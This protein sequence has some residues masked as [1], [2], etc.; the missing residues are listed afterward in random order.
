MPHEDHRQPAVFR[1]AD[2]GGC[3]FAHLARLTGRP[4][5]QARRDGLHRVDDEKL[6]L[7]L[8][9]VAEDRGEIGLAREVELVVQGTGALGTQAHLAERL[10]G[11]DVEHPAARGRGAGGDFEQ[12]CRLADARL[13]RQQDRGAGHDAPAEHAVELAHPRGAARGLA[14]VDLGDGARRTGG[15]EGRHRRSRDAGGGRRFDDG[16]PLLA[17]TAAA[18]PFGARPP[19]LRAPI[20]QGARRAF[21]CHGSTLAAASDMRAARAR[22]SRCAARA[23]P[24]AKGRDTRY[25]TKP[26]PRVA[27]PR[28]RQK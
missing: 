22:R 25:G 23:A 17:F 7:R 8:V 4:V 2:E 9:D 16:A 5:D 13:A 12:Q 15:G 26:P 10:F 21:G 11:A 27:T 19:A 1:D 20:G 28:E 14:R 3:H 18:D 24:M 6:G